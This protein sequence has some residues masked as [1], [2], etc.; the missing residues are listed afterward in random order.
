MKMFIQ[1]FKKV[2]GREILRQYR[3]GHVLFFSFVITALLGFSKKSLEIVRLAVDNRKLCK[4]RKRCKSYITSYLDTHQEVK[5]CTRATKIWFLWLQGIENAPALVKSCYQ[6]LQK[7]IPD[8]EIILLTE[9]NYREFVKFPDYIQ[10]KIDMGVITKTHMSDLLR[11]ELLNRYGGTWI[12]ATVYCSGN[13]IPEYMLDSDLFLFQSL[14]PGLDGKCTCISSWFI[15][16]CTNHP[17]LLLTQSLLYEYWK[18]NTKMFDYFLLH[19][20]FQLAIEVYSEEWSKVIPF[21]NSAPHILLLRLF[22]VYDEKIWEAVK[23]MVPFHKLTYKFNEN[24]LN[25]RNTYYNMIFV[26]EEMNHRI[27]K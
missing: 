9:Y 23:E 11:L 16:A 25:E 5:S 10:Q 6:S 8:R 7:N 2:G 21:S 1:L 14:K 24:M 27:Y 12:D 18:N 22:D 15:T 4:L 3:Q 26:D 13:N 20:F 17:I 19:D